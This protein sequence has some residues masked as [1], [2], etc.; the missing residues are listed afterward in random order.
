[1]L[2]FSFSTFQIHNQNIYCSSTLSLFSNPRIGVGRELNLLYMVVVII[3]AIVV[4]LIIIGRLADQKEKV[5]K[6]EHRKDKKQLQV[7]LS[8]QEQLAA[9]YFMYRMAGV[10]GEF[11]E[12]EKHAYVKMC[13]A[14]AIAPN[15][16]ELIAF[17]AMGDGVPL[18]ILRNAETKKQDWILGLIIIMMMADNKIDDAELTLV[19]ELALKI[20]IPQDRFRRV[21]EEVIQMHAQSCQ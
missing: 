19:A 10:D 13:A 5:Y 18:Q 21:S 6:D 11:A 12:L 17:I 3:I 4:A 15:D 16:T 2:F 1:M 9:L 8:R 20:G 14:F 7:V